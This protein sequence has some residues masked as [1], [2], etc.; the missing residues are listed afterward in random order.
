MSEL[1]GDSGIHLLLAQNRKNARSVVSHFPF[2]RSQFPVG[3]KQINI[4]KRLLRMHF[5]ERPEA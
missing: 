1:T 5:R 3:S 4:L 2:A